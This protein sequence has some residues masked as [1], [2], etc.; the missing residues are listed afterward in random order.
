MQWTWPSQGTDHVW[1]KRWCATNQNI[2]AFNIF[3]GSL[4]EASL[5]KSSNDKWQ[6]KLNKFTCRQCNVT[7]ENRPHLRWHRSFGLCGGKRFYHLL[8]AQYTRLACAHD[9]SDVICCSIFQAVSIFQAAGQFSKLC[10]SNG[11]GVQVWK[12]LRLQTK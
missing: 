6:N 12:E 10:K 7:Q 5:E 11:R 4:S 8:S 2:I 1:W 3:N 9:L